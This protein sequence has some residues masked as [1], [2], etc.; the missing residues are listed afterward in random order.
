LHNKPFVL[1]M[2]KH[3]NVHQDFQLQVQVV[4]VFVYLYP[5]LEFQFCI[6]KINIYM[7]LLWRPY[8]QENVQYH[9]FLL[10]QIDSQHQS[11]HQQY[12][13]VNH[14]L[15]MQYV[16]HFLLMLLEFQEHLKE[17]QN[18]LLMVLVE[19]HLLFYETNKKLFSFINKFKFIY[20]RTSYNS[21]SSMNKS[22]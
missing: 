7:I 10:F 19:Q 2:Y 21:I 9:Y 8:V 16:N 18:I 5:E 3:L 22:S 14:N 4:V 20:W 17:F 11:K 6:I 13:S 15:Q 1:L 12:M